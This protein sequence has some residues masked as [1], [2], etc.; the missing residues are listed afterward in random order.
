MQ[1][2]SI[3]AASPGGRG[4]ARGRIWGECVCVCV[5]DETVLTSLITSCVASDND[6]IS[7]SLSSII[8]KMKMIKVRSL[9][10]SKERTGT[11]PLA[12]FPEHSPV[13]KEGYIRL[14]FNP[15]SSRLLIFLLRLFPS[16]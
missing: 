16:S 6:L 7:L 9:Q 8:Y 5:V 3:S 15:I 14:L 4:L 13:F 10:G 2:L 1:A 11:K 12:D